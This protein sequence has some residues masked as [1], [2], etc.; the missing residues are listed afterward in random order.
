MFIGSLPFI[1]RGGHFE[2]FYFSHLL[3]FVYY[4]AL[5]IHAPDCW[6]W[7]F[8]PLTMFAFELIF[9]ILATLSPD[10][11]G[12]SI[13]QAGLLLPSK[14]KNLFKKWGFYC[15]FIHTH[16]CINVTTL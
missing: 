9:R 14:G 4:I 6:K 12:Q 8:V 13:I 15:F 10:G 1:R 3:Y 2:I 5:I 16:G 11:K 7:T